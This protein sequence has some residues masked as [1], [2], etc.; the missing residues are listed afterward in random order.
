MSR[1]SSWWSGIKNFTVAHKVWS[2]IIVI[3]VLGGGWW[4][5]GKVNPSTTPTQYVLTT[6]QSGTIVETV[7]GSGQVTPSNEITIN[8]QTSGQITQVLVKDDQQVSAGQALAYIESTSEYTSV[9]SAKSSLQSA[10]LSLQK[11]QE[12]PTSLQTTQKIRTRYRKPSRVCRP[13]KT[14]LENEYG[15]AYSD[16]VATF[17]DLPTVQTQLQDVDIGTEPS[18]GPQWNIDFYQSA[19]ENWDAIDAISYRNAA[20]TDYQ[21]AQSAYPQA[22]ADFQ[23]ATSQSSTS[24]I[25]SDLAETY[26]TVQDEQTALNSANSFIEFYENQ[27]TN[28]PANAG[29]RGQHRPLDTFF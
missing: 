17:L 29:R 1:L 28:H 14:N 4:I 25:A 21:A 9:L 8:P 5:Y 7:S 18:K 24:T 3:V 27:V 10:Q 6:V 2:V 11:L 26:S 15:S 20:Y 22:Y 13:T 23:Q 12:P 16:M 19:V